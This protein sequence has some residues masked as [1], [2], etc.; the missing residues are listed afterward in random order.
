MKYPSDLIPGTLLKRYKRFLADIELND[1]SLITAHCANPGAMITLKTPGS[2]VFVTKVP[3]H[4]DRKLRYDWHVIAVGN[5]L[6]GVNT[7]FPN[8]IVYEALQQGKIKELNCYHTIKPEVKYGLQNSRVDFL[9]EQENLPDC[10][11]EIKNVNHMETKGI[12]LFPDA[13]TSRGVKHLQELMYIVN[14]GGRAV[15]LY[16]VQRNDCNQF[17]VAEHI[18]KIYGETVIQAKKAG[19]EFLCY[20]CDVSLQSISLKNK[21]QIIGSDVYG[22]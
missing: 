10:Y 11:L 5:C 22:K 18:D 17:A 9:L 19:V 15:L 7:S 13:V 8:K 16:V 2:K 20:S 14:Q 6:V 4:I 3:D 12:A 1:G 21:I